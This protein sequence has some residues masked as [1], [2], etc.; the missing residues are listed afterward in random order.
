MSLNLRQIVPIYRQVMDEF[1]NDLGKNIKIIFE[2]TITSVDNSFNDPV[3]PESLLKPDF[4]TSNSIPSPTKVENSETIKALI[5]YNPK[6]FQNFG[7]K[8]NA[9]A[10][11]IRLK[12]FMSD[13]PSLI[14]CKYIIPN[15]DS[16]SLFGGKFRLIRAAIPRGIYE[17]R[18]AYTYWESTDV[19]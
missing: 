18:Y 7:I 11:I 1:I 3:R 12:T 17:D 2:S 4:K 6:D 9:E 15:F 19:P 13:I 16:E 5:Q 8:I 14:R 10:T